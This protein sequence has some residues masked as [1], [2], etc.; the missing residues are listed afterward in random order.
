MRRVLWGL[1]VVLAVCAGHSGA[2][3]VQEAAP[4]EAPRA[5]SEL[6]DLNTATAMEL[7]TLPGVGPRTAERILEYRREHGGF[8]R[9]EDLMDVRGIGERT[10]L[11]LKP[12][13]RVAAPE[14]GLEPDADRRP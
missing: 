3:Q 10:F 7:D 14:P 6:I 4:P 2:A 11:R 9:I 5:Q 1:A 8:E 13:V 12:L